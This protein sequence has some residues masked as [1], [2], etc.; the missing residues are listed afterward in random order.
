MQINELKNFIKKEKII[1]LIFIL[2]VVFSLIYIFTNRI[3]ELFMFW[4]EIMTFLYS[5]FISV[6]AAVIFYVFQVYIP[7]LKKS[8]K[9]VKVFNEEYNYFKLDTIQI[10]IWVLNKHEKQPNDLIELNDFKQYFDSKSWEEKSNW[11]ELI[12]KIEESENDEHFKDLIFQLELLHKKVNF[13]LLSVDM[14]DDVFAFFH[15]LDKTLFRLQYIKQDNDR[16][17]NDYKLF[18][19][20]LREIFSGRSFISWY[21]DMDFV[22]KN[23]NDINNQ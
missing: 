8:K 10:F 1:L 14:P 19:R 13:L 3:P 15:R 20:T 6:I 2:S 5:I 7:N 21:S 12:N 18:W 23:L 22:E 17:Q 9:I 16:Y 4:K 11:S